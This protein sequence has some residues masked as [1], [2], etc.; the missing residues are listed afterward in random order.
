MTNRYPTMC[1]GD[2]E[3]ATE[4]ASILIGEQIERRIPSKED[5]LEIW[6]RVKINIDSWFGCL[7]Q[8]PPCYICYGTGIRIEKNSPVPCTCATGQD[9]ATRKHEMEWDG[10]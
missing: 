7:G 5:A 8:W 3:R 9:F 2:I 4:I 1:E 6:E 10:A